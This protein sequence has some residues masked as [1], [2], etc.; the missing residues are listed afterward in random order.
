MILVNFF[1]AVVSVLFSNPS[2]AQQYSILKLNVAG[3]ASN[4]LS[5]A[6]ERTI[7]KKVSAQVTYQSGVFG[8]QGQ[9]FSGGE[10]KVTGHGIIPEVRF[11]PFK[12]EKG[13]PAGSL[14]VGIDFRY[15][16][17][18]EQ[19]IYQNQNPVAFVNLGTLYNYGVEAG[20]KHSYKRLWVEMLVGYGFGKVTNDYSSNSNLIPT[21]YTQNF[22]LKNENRF[23]RWELSVGF[24]ISKRV[25]ISKKGEFR[26][27]SIKN[28][29]GV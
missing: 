15:L 11:Y 13:M 14:F 1:L 23:M 16:R 29:E 21:N 24:I 17:F 28:K 12:G 26:A 9:T 5:I 2:H 22:F 4:K 6:Y 8:R 27:V 20:Y 25:V 7:F 19:Y 3:L 18:N 10:Y